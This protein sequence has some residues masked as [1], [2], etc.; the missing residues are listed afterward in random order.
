MVCQSGKATNIIYMG[1]CLLSLL[2]Q[3]F[4]IH[5]KLK[6]LK[7]FLKISSIIYLFPEQIRSDLCNRDTEMEMSTM[8]S[9][10]KESL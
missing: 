9:I 8:D 10:S 1:V 5:I 6:F 3:V 2:L 7:I 4:P